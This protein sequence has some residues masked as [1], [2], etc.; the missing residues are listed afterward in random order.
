[1]RDE[2]V[3]LQLVGVWDQHRGVNLGHRARVCAGLR[4][5]GVGLRHAHRAHGRVL[6]PVRGGDEV[7]PPQAPHGEPVHADR[8][9]QCPVGRFL[10][11]IGQ[12]PSVVSKSNRLHVVIFRF[13]LFLNLRYI[14]TDSSKMIGSFHEVW[15]INRLF[16]KL[17]LLHL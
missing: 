17:N 12:N 2:E 5:L 13:F 10:G 16:L 6:D 3:V 1:M 14:P 11:I 15:N 4:E 7:L 9:G 8:A